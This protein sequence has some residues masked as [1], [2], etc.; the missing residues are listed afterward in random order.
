[1]A[2]VVGIDKILAYISKYRFRKIKLSKGADIVYTDSVKSN[3]EEAQLLTRFESW[4][5]DFIEPDNFKEYKLEL[6]GTNKEEAEV[7]Q[8]TPVIKIAVQFNQKESMG[9]YRPQ[10]NYGSG[11]DVKEYTALAVKNAELVGQIGRLEEKLNELLT[12]EEEP[13]QQQSL[14]NK[15]GEVLLSRAD[16]IINLLIMKLAPTT[17]QPIAGVNDYI[18]EE[19]L[20]PVTDTERFENE[21]LDTIDEFR[22]IN[23]DILTDLKKLLKLA[24][25]NKPLFDMLIKQLRNM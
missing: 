20:A 2:E 8:L 24:Q 23:P 17:A 19:A 15:I 21:V 3:N 1:M 7:K 5:L 22:S 12:A 25:T 11:F 14:G 9:S 18:P 10:N 4:V 13:E 6:F 16:D